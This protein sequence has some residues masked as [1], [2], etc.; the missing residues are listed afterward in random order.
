MSV[1]RLVRAQ[2]LPVS[3]EEIWDF[4]SSPINL[5]TITPPDMGFEV[6]SPEPPGRMYAG[7]IIT[8][9]V[10]PLWG[11]PM[12]WCTEITHVEDGKYFVDEQRQGPYA[13]WHHQHHIRPVSGGVYME[14]IVHYRLPL[15]PLGDLVHPWLVKPRLEQIFDY[16]F[17]VLEERFGHM[18]G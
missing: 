9:I 10:R 14:D 7:Q 12:R 8:Y 18:P 11:I 17:R 1:H 6:T 2:T 4:I 3:P 5:K 16:R 13:M 15:G